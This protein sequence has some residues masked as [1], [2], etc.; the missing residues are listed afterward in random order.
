MKKLFTIIAILMPLMAMAQSKNVSVDSVGTLARQLPEDVRFK[1]AELKVTG[2]LDGSDLKL[3]QQI[4]TRN[5][6]NKKVADECLV[7]SIDLSEAVIMEGKAGMKTENNTLP[8]GLFSGAKSLVKAILPKNILNV[9]RNCFD[10]CPALAE[11]TIPE[12]VITIGS[13]AFSD[14]TSLTEIRLPNLL[15]TIEHDAFEQCTSLVAIDIPESVV[16]LENDVFGG[17]K[18]LAKVN[19]Q[20][21]ITSIGSGT[22]GNVKHWPRLPFPKAS[23]QW[24]TMPSATARA[25]PPSACPTSWT[26]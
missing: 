8:A 6:T 21:N 1:V 3:L 20:G 14:C 11:V 7:T 24:A 4:V 25:W 15:T 19:I 22:S 5:K 18:A 9:S 17:C 26:R 16:T 12:T 13:N 23:S 10:N 2:P